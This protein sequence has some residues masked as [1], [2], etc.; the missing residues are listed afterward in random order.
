MDVSEVG[1]RVGGRAEAQ[2]TKGERGRCGVSQLLT[3]TSGIKAVDRDVGHLMLVGCENCG[4]W[5]G[6]KGGGRRTW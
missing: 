6:G 3:E 5:R 1:G 2:E 4:Q